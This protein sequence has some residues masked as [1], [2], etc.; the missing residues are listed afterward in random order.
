MLTFMLG[1]GDESMKGA[2]VLAV[3]VGVG[4]GGNYANRRAER[5]EN[6]CSA[7][8]RFAQAL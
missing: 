2:V 8:R 1:V 3:A 6:V 4:P 7:G 5:G